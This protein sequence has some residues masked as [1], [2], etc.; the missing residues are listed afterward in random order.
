MSREG[1]RENETAIEEG[2]RYCQIGK[3]CRR[4]EGGFAGRSFVEWE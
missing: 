2:D 4:K 1:G 3:G